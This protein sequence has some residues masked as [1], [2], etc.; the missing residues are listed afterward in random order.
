M[1]QSPRT[2]GDVLRDQRPC[3]R[4]VAHGD[5]GVHAL[6]C[7]THQSFGPVRDTIAE[8]ERDD[9]VTRQLEVNAAY[10]FL[11]GLRPPQPMAT[12]LPWAPA[13]RV[14]VDARD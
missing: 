12:I 11:F 8:A 1:N 14:E 2:V 9:C 13:A 10:A 5:A 4:V 7:W 6:F 3:V